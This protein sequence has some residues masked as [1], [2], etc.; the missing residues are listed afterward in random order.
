MTHLTPLLDTLLPRLHALYVDIQVQ[1]GSRVSRISDSFGTSP[2][3]SAAKISLLIVA[4][5]V[6]GFFVVFLLRR[7][8]AKA[9][10]KTDAESLFLKLCS[11]HEL[12]KR[13]RE[14]LQEVAIGMNEGY[15]ITTDPDAP[16]PDTR[17]NPLATI[18]VR[19]T[20][21]SQAIAQETSNERKE[22]LEALF[23]K[24]FA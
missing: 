17:A 13:D 24:L 23:R 7:L 8:L 6:V 20:L 5:V 19:K 1:K 18:F 9:T 16:P 11:A 4:L 22:R 14:L 2:G 12:S 15:F 21:F 3:A 10:A